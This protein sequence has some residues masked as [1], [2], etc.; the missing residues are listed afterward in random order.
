MPLRIIKNKLIAF[1]VILISIQLSLINVAFSQEAGFEVPDEITVT[2]RKRQESL[3]DVPISIS[4]FNDKAMRDRNITDAYGVAAFTPNFQFSP[5]L[6]RRLDVPN[7]RGQF[8][9]LISSVEPN[10]SFFVDGVYVGGSIASTSLANLQQVE[11]LRGPQSAQFGRATFAGAVNYITRKPTDE[12]L[13]EIN[14]KIGQDG[15]YGLGAWASGPVSAGESILKDKLFFFAGADWQEWDGEWR[16]NLQ[17]GQVNSY[18]QN[19]FLGPYVWRNNLPLPGDPPCPAGSVSPTFD[20]GGPVGCAPTIGDNETKLGGQQTK[21]GTFR[22]DY[23]PTDA[24]EFKIKYERGYAADQHYSYLFVPPG[25]ERYCLN[26]DPDGNIIDPNGIA[27]TRSTG[28]VCGELTDDGYTNQINIPN[29]LRGVITRPPSAVG[30]VSSGNAPSPNGEPIPDPIP[31]PFLGLREDTR[32]FLFETEADI[33]DYLL[34]ARYSHSF[35]DSEYVRDLDR[36]YALGPVATGLFESYRNE[37][38]NDDSIEVRLASPGDERLRWQAGYYFYDYD[39]D[40]YQRDFN[41]FARFFV[42]DVGK[43][44]TRNQAIFGG[45]D[46]DITPET[47]FS[48]E[49]R[50]AEDEKTRISANYT[51][52]NSLVPSCVDISDGNEVQVSNTVTLSEDFVIAKGRWYNFSPRVSLTH[53]ISEDLTAYVQWAEGD[54][55]GGFNFPYFDQ[56]VNPD[57]F[58]N[59]DCSELSERPFI[60]PEK[61]QTYEIG[62]K[63][64]FF[65]GRI[66]ANLALFYIDWTNQAVNVMD[67][68]K[69]KTGVPLCE[70]QMVTDNVGESEVLGAEVELNWFINDQFSMTIGYGYS[71][72]EIKAGYI[73]DE[74]AVLLC[75]E[76]CFETFIA[77]GLPTPEAE[78]LFSAAGDVSGKKAPFVPKQNISLS[79][80]YEKEFNKSTNWFFRNDFLFESKRYSTVSNLAWAPSQWVWNGRIGLESDIFTVALYI[81]NI[82]NEKSPIQIQDFPLFDG[83]AGYLAPGSIQTSPETEI[84]GGGTI[85]QSAFQISPRR[86]RNAGLTAQIRF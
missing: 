31:V 78:E 21:V 33:G 42:R 79:A 57:A 15:T 83:S 26:R 64:K 86:S 17:P 58:Y 30:N 14:I 7:F 24:L 74:L 36:S 47:T 2:A 56:D 37:I 52:P 80:L 55:P 1:L 10:A 45:F 4:V 40:S 59:A 8:G 3:Q 67:C 29:L 20:P 65:D 69:T 44:F 25:N 35:W 76:G 61:A 9:P 38:R 39:Q 62:A 77:S 12:F 75:P 66:Q 63:G 41:G 46:F 5:N 28:F 71:D 53:Q 34:T 16:N 84:V 82:T 43:S 32:R 22:L 23:R 85:Y 49:G 6:G 68:I 27:G 54:K 19:T 81:D 60:E 51:P 11:I 50:Y 70:T 13:S 48:F 72:S 18:S 73:D